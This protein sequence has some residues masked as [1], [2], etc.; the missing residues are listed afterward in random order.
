LLEIDLQLADLERDTR[1]D[2][3]EFLHNTIDRDDAIDVIATRFF[4][5]D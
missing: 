4:G 5:E 3:F 1:E 2:L